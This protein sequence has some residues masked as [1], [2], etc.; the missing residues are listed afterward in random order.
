[1]ATFP[2]RQLQEEQL[3]LPFPYSLISVSPYLYNM[4][5]WAI[6]RK[7]GER[8]IQLFTRERLEKR[9]NE[10][11]AVCPN[12]AIRMPI[13]IKK[14][15]LFITIVGMGEMEPNGREV[16]AIVKI[17]VISA[18]VVEQEPD[19]RKRFFKKLIE[20]MGFPCVAKNEGLEIVVKL[21]GKNTPVEM[22]NPNDRHGQAWKYYV[23]QVEVG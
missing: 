13:K 11:R 6:N 5:V 21:Y 3:P 14:V 16:T 22:K 20:Q 1:M 17:P 19:D 23:A 18:T 12:T 15:E 7:M 4:L 10:F 2:L 8:R 9:V